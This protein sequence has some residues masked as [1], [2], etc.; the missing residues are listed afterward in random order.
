M[1]EQ[2]AVN[3]AQRSDANA[4]EDVIAVIE[5]NFRRC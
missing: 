1:R 4:I 5:Q 2:Y 3:L